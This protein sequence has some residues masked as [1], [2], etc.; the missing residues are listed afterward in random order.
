[1]DYSTLVGVSFDT[2]TARVQCRGVMP[3]PL[4]TR[5]PPGRLY[6]PEYYVYTCARVGLT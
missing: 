5:P 6:F 3:P 1:M 2:R 4:V